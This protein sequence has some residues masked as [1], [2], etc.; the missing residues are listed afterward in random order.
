[1]FFLQKQVFYLFK[2]KFLFMYIIGD[3]FNN[4]DIVNELHLK[5]VVSLYKTQLKNY[6]MMD[7]V[8]NLSDRT[9]CTS[10]HH[11]E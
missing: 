3:K 6:Y 8:A 11:E 2:L 7:A 1:M 4:D 5:Q 9:Y 10:F